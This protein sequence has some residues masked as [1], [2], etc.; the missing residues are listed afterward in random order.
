MEGYIGGIASQCLGGDL[1][2][3]LSSLGFGGMSTEITQGDQTAIVDD[4]FAGFRHRAEDTAYFSEIVSNRTVRE[5][6]V[7]LFTRQIAVE[8]ELQI[9]RPGSLTAIEDAPEHGADSVPNLAPTHPRWCAE[10][11][12]MFR[13]EHRNV[14]IVVKNRQVAAPENDDR[15]T[16][17]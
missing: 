1:A 10:S 13:A 4:A 11:P 6:E 17:V 14:C 3:L 16:R 7:T 12:R 5:C 2:R 9:L 8:D 15:K